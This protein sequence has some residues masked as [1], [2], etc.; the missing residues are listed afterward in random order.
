MSKKNLLLLMRLQL[1]IIGALLVASQALALPGFAQRLTLS[2]KH[3]SLEEVFAEIRK[4][5]GYDFIVDGQL[6]RQG[7][8][9]DVDLVDVSVTEALDEVLRDQP[10]AYRIHD[11]TVV[12]TAKPA[13]KISLPVQQVVS[14]RV[15]DVAGKPISGVSIQLKVGSTV[16]QSKAATANDGS[17]SIQ[18]PAG[19]ATLAFSHISYMTTEVPVNGRSQINV[20]LQEKY[21]AIE[22]T[23]VIAYGNQQ[24][25]NITGS[26][27]TITADQLKDLAPVVNL[28]ES[29]KGFAAGVMVEQQ[30]GQPG[31]ATKVRIR[32][33][34][35]L[36]GS[37]QPLYVVDGVPVIAESNIPSDGSTQNAQLINQ[38]LNSPLNNLNPQDIESMSI[39]KDA[40]ATA[41]YG[42]RAANGVVIITTKKG[43]ATQKPSYQVN[44]SFAV[45]EAQT[46][47]MLS[48]EQFRLLW[49]EAAN[50]ST[51]TNA[52]LT[53]IRNGTYFGSANTDWRKELGVSNAL[54]KQYNAS[55]SG[56]NERLRYYA[57][58][59]HTDQ[60]GTFKGAGFER[61]NMLVNMELSATD[62]LKF[63]TSI[64]LSSSDQQ[65]LGADLLTNVYSF[66]PDLPVYN[67]DGSYTFSP[68]F[69][70]ENPVAM[71][72]MTDR[73][74][75]FLLVGSA[76]GE[77][78]FARHFRLK[79]AL[80][81]N[82]NNGNQRSFYPSFTNLGGFNI[83][84][85]LGLGYAQEGTSRI[86]SHL[87][88]NTLNYG[89]LLADI[90]QLDVVV[91]A[92]WQ[93]D[94]NGFLKA[95]GQGF[96][97]DEVL[98]NLSSATTN[99]LIQSNRTQS[100]L[101]SYFGR[102][103]YT[104]LDRYIV[105]ASARTDAS[106]KFGQDSQWAF[107]PTAAVGWRV[108][109]EP[110]MQSVTFLDELKL[111]GSVGVI[112]QQNFG[113]YQWRTLFESD[114][115]DGGPA[116]I[117]NQLGDNN[118]RWELTTQTDIGL[119]FSL[120]N[121]RLSGAF[122][123]YHKLTDDLHYYTNI[124]ISTGF[125]QTVSNLGTTR[126]EG[127]ELTLDG[128]LIK[129]KDFSWS[130]MVNVS[131]NWNT[132][133]SLNDDYLNSTTGMIT[134]PSGGGVL[135]IGKPVGLMYGFA[136]DG[137][138]QNQAELDALNA[139]A[140]DGVYQMALTAPGDLKFRDI[141]G[142]DGVPDGKITAADQTVI[143]NSL[144]DF[145]GGFSS[146]FRYKGIR[147]TALFNYSIG[148]DLRWGSQSA[149]TNFQ[150]GSFGENKWDI[151]MNRWTPERP[152][153]NPRAVFGD[154]NQNARISSYYVHDASFLRLNNLILEYTLPQHI[155]SRTNFLNNLQVFGTA[156]NLMTF[157][158]YP[159]PNP[160]TTNLFNND[161][162]AGLDNSRYPVA[163]TFTLGL[164]AGF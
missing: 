45:Q 110:F 107:F 49:T 68:F 112:G 109:E 136:A 14:G 41:I 19:D 92:S 146:T 150:G 97:Q 75:T 29:M 66:R 153:E 2:K 15:T 61:Y 134:P 127:L 125:V 101:V 26:V 32:G 76:F 135:Q 64:N 152:T 93:G 83:N 55:A 40:S 80:S 38:G 158:R 24:R 145:W 133:V 70:R 43:S 23:V 53:A 90:H 7:H 18:V 131:R 140:V 6:L 52:F 62:Y 99:F 108:S 118:L 4:Q 1:V 147:L 95:S 42:S 163:K 154:P 58:I 123:Y 44:T 105:T 77:L 119:D 94:S 27:A 113:P 160:E 121:N 85:G 20:T 22:E 35:S 162:S 128:Q 79:S 148:N 142:P 34:S 122:D 78:Q 87:W 164:R 91:G 141:S 104:L 65:S 60:E 31:A 124:P 114:S 8:P 115:Y 155:L 13:I 161:V 10:F 33:S 57:S 138:I 130:M 157:T 50:N 47:K 126:N 21:T 5:S 48:L 100:G 12:I 72:K 106:S 151:A 132:L 51:Q 144:P 116:L 82:Y 98:T 56:G 36:I 111:R 54:T 129:G 46:M 149:A 88:E 84:T 9:L 28:E 86:L 39:L 103:N 63:G 156:T 59:G 25:K 159:G 37:N 102:A 3:V 16:A 73:N 89:R 30:S 120:F 74:N 81:L 137:I 96:P 17:Y 143:G 139:G 117:Q 67:E 69:A 11:N 71:S